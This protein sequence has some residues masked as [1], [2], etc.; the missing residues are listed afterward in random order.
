MFNIIEKGEEESVKFYKEWVEEVKKTVPKEKLLVFE[1]KDGWG[2]LCE[3]LNV[4]TPEGPF[5]HVNDTA[6]INKNFNSLK[7][8]SRLVFLVLPIVLSIAGALLYSK[9]S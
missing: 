6:S 8:H 7:V 3:F 9:M 2:P 1:P 4:S 5:P